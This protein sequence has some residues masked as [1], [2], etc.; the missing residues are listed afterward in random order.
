MNTINVDLRKIDHN[1]T[2][3]VPC[4]NCHKPLAIR[5]DKTT[6]C[7]CGVE[8]RRSDDSPQTIESIIKLE[9]EWWLL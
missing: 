2:V 9:K 3:F 1:E 4:P 6:R 7:I 8:I 5:Y